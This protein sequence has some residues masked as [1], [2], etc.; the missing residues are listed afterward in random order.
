MLPEVEV[1]MSVAHDDNGDRVA[2]TGGTSSPLHLSPTGGDRK[3]NESEVDASEGH[4]ETAHGEQFEIGEHP[5]E[6]TQERKE[7]E[8]KAMEWEERGEEDM[9]IA[10]AEEPLECF[11]QQSEGA[12][13]EAKEEREVQD[14]ENIQEGEQSTREHNEQTIDKDNVLN[15][16]QLKNKNILN[17]ANISR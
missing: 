17:V 8:E 5:E 1:S 4:Q 9:D 12:K 6:G 15:S 11:H 14:K 2:S 10:E 3:G 16:S 13:E 7:N